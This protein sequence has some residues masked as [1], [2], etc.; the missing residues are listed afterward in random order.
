MCGVIFYILKKT[1][2]IKDTL[3]FLIFTI[4]EKNTRKNYEGCLQKFE[5]GIH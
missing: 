1:T 4:Q 5:Y 2:T 3:L